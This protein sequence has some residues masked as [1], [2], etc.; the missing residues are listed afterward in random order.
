MAP[1]DRATYYKSSFTVIW[2][3]IILALIGFFSGLYTIDR[4]N[5]DFYRDIFT[6]TR[7]II[8]FFFGILLSKYVRDLSTFYKCFAIFVLLASI[9][10]LSAAAVAIQNF[11]SFNQY[12]HASGLTN[13]DEAIILGIFISAFF[14]WSLRRLLGKIGFAYKA[15]S[16]IILISF[17]AY[18]SRTMI[19]TLIIL[20]FFMADTLNVRK[21]SYPKNKRIFSAV[22]M[23]AVVF[24]S[25]SFL[26]AANPSN[27]LLKT[28]VEKFERSSEE[29]FW[30]AE[31][32]AT[33]TVQEIQDNWRG[34]EAYQ[35]IM[36]FNDGTTVQQFFGHGFGSLVD[37]GIFML[38]SGIEW[39]KVPILHNGYVFIVV[40]CGLVGLLFYLL[41]LYR[42]GFSKIRNDEF[43]D[44][45]LYYSYQML[46]GL[47]L[48][49]LLNTFTV[50]GL[51]NPIGATMPV[52]F[53]FF[54]GR[55]QRRKAELLSRVTNHEFSEA[56]VLN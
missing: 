32:N 34:Y 31:A 54:W 3:L 7:V 17:M 40:K 6:F 9:R 38:L 28:L 44:L 16:W 12:R 48:L 42:I 24:T 25:L 29:V 14:N 49:T 43:D 11:S 51:F 33:A 55:V 26:A 2:P 4:I 35:G 23:I 10:H 39:D 52:L 47:S 27:V 19:L 18:F 13:F 8:Y 5:R 36:M 41:F 56:L 53:G 46:S 37:L 15:I 21:F 30:N 45:E 22:I 20:I 50:T 1:Y